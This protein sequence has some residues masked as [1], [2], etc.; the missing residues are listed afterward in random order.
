MQ[1]TRVRSLIGELRSHMLYSNK[2]H[3]YW[4]LGAEWESV[5]NNKRSHM[6]QQRPH[7]LQLKPDTTK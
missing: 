6:M 5:H 7:V 3:V 1:E 2:G 4:I